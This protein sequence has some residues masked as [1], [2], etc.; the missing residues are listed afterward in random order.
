MKIFFLVFLLSNFAFLNGNRELSDLPSMRYDDLAKQYNRNYFQ[1]ITG[2]LAPILEEVHDKVYSLPQKMS[3]YINKKHPYDQQEAYVRFDTDNLSASEKMYLNQRKRSVQQGLQKYL[4][5]DSLEEDQQP[6]IALCFSGGGFRA[7]MLSAGALVGAESTGLL[8]CTTYIASLSGST[9]I[10]GQW[11][12]AKRKLTDLRDTLYKKTNHGLSHLTK[13]EDRVTVL[14]HWFT[15]GLNRQHLSS[16]DIYGPLLANTLLTDFGKEKLT[17]TLS[18]SHEHIIQG[19]YPMPL[20]TSISTNIDKPYT[21]VT[22]TPFEVGAPEIGYIPTWA[23]GR[24]FKNGKSVNYAPEQ[25][26]GYCFG[27]FGSAFAV[28]IKDILRLSAE[29]VL[30]IKSSLPA[31]VADTMSF[32]MN[33]SIIPALGEV[34]LAPSMLPNF[35]YGEKQSIFSSDKTLGVVDAGIDFNLPFPPL[36]DAARKVDLIVVY[37]SSAGNVGGEIKKAA[38]YA[39]AKGIAFPPVPDDIGNHLF[40]VLKDPSNEKCPVVIYMPRIKNSDYEKN[41]DPEICINNDYCSTFNFKYSKENIEQLSGL[42]KH[43]LE[44]FDEQIKNEIKLLYKRK[45]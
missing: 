13:H 19:R 10:T 3:G 1:H 12:G 41:F 20:Y 4:S 34:R 28:D 35:S 21:W 30:K 16:I 14:R 15:K 36:L 25:S 29:S 24:T 2:Y 7:M 38:V 18:D 26:L 44:Q 42:A 45:K 39:K 6:S 5:D 9:W 40:S 22:F 31:P 33:K 11:I 32:V 23:Y 27:I 17:V 43:A 8:D 37:D